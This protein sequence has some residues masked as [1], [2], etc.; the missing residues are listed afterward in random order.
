[1]VWLQS[2]P[3][4][5]IPLIWWRHTKPNLLGREGLLLG[6]A[7]DVSTR[8]GCKEHDPTKLSYCE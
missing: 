5:I 7:G 8:N 3:W 1:M 6:D 4:P 2:C